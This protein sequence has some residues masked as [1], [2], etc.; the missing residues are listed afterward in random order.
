MVDP[1]VGIQAGRLR[2]SLE[3]LYLLSGKEDPVRIELP[4][5]TYVPTFRG[6]RGG[7][8]AGRRLVGPARGG[9]KT[10]DGLAAVGR[11]RWLR[12]RRPLRGSGAARA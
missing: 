10:G 11:R 4:K 8:G 2:R 5:G 1:I 3:R 12:G 9:P 6:G 7:R